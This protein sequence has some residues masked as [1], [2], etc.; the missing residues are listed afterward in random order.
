MIKKHGGNVYKFAKEHQVQVEDVIDFS[1]NINPFGLSNVVKEA[2]PSMFDKVLNYPD[3]NYMDLREAIAKFENIYED[4]IVLGNGAIECIFLLAEHL[5]AKHLVIPVPTFVEYERAF[6]KYQTKI[7]YYQMNDMILDID[8]LIESFSDRVDAVIVC[9]PNNPTGSLVKRTDLEKLLN[10]TKEHQIYLIID[11]AFID[12]TDDEDNNTMKTYLKSYSNLII[13]KSL[14]KFFAIP[15]LRLGYLMTSHKELIDSINNSRMPWSI[16]S[17]AS[18]VG[19]LVLKDDSYIEKTKKWI[20]KERQWF[21]ESI[22]SIDG[23]Y[24]YVSQGNYIFFRS[25]EYELDKKLAEYS[26]MIRNCNNYEGLSEGYFRVAIKDRNSNL[27]L[28]S[29]IK[30]ILWKS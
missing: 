4:Q 25:D 10:Y 23:I 1:A 3:P 6:S 12:F 13:L 15:G 14:T 26:I 29:C 24:P 17:I 9:N 16:N 18:Q 5:K 20:V 28:I 30:E 22:L 27:K 11:E 8:C 19:E 7:C 21:Y 2:I